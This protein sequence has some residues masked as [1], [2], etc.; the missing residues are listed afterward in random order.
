MDGNRARMAD[1]LTRAMVTAAT[2]T[3]A[4]ALAGTAGAGIT[5]NSSESVPVGLYRVRPL[6]GDPARGQVVGVCLTRGA[7]VLARDRGYVHPQGLEPWV[8]GARCGSELAV[9][10]KPVAAVPGDTVEVTTSGVY[11]NGS[12]LPKG[13][14]L[15]EDRSG[16]QLPRAVPRMRV[17][18]SGEFWIQSPY[19]TR[20]FDS[21]VYGPVYREQMVD[22]R[23]PLLT[24]GSRRL[25]PSAGEAMPAGRSPRSDSP[26]APGGVSRS[27]ACVGVPLRRGQ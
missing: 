20:S 3:V 27:R 13:T 8:Y 11:V 16:R 19:T 21:R 4:L 17:L 10:G 9:I 25:R 14:I 18:G 15:S 5:Y 24:S 22:L 6:R 2:W 7:A 23:V 12:P 26:A 1:R